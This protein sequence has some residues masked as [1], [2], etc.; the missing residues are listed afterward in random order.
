[1]APGT[2][3]KHLGSLVITARKIE[4]LEIGI[5]IE[6]IWEEGPWRAVRQNDH[7]RAL[8]SISVYFNRQRI[9]KVIYF[10]MYCH[11]NHLSSLL[12]GF[13]SQLPHPASAR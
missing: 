4:G 11:K 8:N 5:K 2:G 1:M 10:M 3:L 6:A 9:F 12:Q 7:W 13:L